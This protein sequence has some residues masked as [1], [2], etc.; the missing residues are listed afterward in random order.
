MSFSLKPNIFPPK[1]IFAEMEYTLF[2]VGGG[3]H[4]ISMVLVAALLL[5]CKGGVSFLHRKRL[6]LLALLHR[7]A[8]LITWH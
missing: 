5:S 8:E 6:A 3:A 1:L 2:L 7:T 4:S